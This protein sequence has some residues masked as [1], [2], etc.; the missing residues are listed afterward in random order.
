M[1]QLRIHVEVIAVLYSSLLKMPRESKNKNSSNA[2]RQRAVTPASA[3]AGAG[4]G[5]SQRAHGVDDSQEVVVK[6]E[7][8]GHG[9]VDIRCALRTSV[10][11]LKRRVLELESAWSS[12]TSVPSR[13]R[14][15]L[16][17]KD[18]A[19]ED[20]HPLSIYPF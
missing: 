3:A 18:F 8:A 7:I 20:D 5:M 16:T 11:E 13:S 4:T 1:L 2:H 6:I 10:A 19:L 12:G 17:Y 14:M 9:S 15:N